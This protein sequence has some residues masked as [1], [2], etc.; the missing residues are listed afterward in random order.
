MLTRAPCSAGSQHLHP[1]AGVTA[2][3]LRHF[4]KSEARPPAAFRPPSSGQAHVDFERAWR[5][6]GYGWVDLLFQ[7]TATLIGST[8]T[9][10]LTSCWRNSLSFTPIN[11]QTETVNPTSRIK[12]ARRCF[13]VCFVT[14]CSLV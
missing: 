9:A 4:M 11:P 6:I 3:Q 1:P 13:N 12:I 10:A 14:M 2:E 8:D 5:Q 7:F